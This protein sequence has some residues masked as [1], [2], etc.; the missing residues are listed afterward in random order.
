MKR[1]AAFLV[2]YL[3]LT[4]GLGTIFHVAQSAE[5]WE[6]ILLPIWALPAWWITAGIGIRLGVYPSEFFRELA[7]AAGLVEPASKRDKQVSN[8]PA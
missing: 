5:I 8:D 7:T 6:F 3:G 2:Y 4:L 1:A